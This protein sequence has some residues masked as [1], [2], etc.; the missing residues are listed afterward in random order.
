[1]LCVH[2]CVCVC[3]R[4]HVFYVSA[5][6]NAAFWDPLS[7]STC[8]KL[9]FVQCVLVFVAIAV[10]WHVSPSESYFLD[11]FLKCL[12]TFPHDINC[13]LTTAPM[14]TM[15]WYRPVLAMLDATTGSSKLPGTHAT[16]LKVHMRV[17]AHV[18]ACVCMCVCV[19]EWVCVCV[20]G[21]G[22]V[23][24]WVCV[25][26]GCTFLC[27]SLFCLQTGL[28]V[29]YHR[30]IQPVDKQSSPVYRSKSDSTVKIVP[31]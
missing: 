15:A 2:V 30:L 23:C 10:N 21:R 1:V 7:S 25:Y 11:Q 4:V 20:C 8:S 9:S 31:C 5:G 6:I 28:A 14:Q 27:P 24:V 26:A 17:C 22:C 13:A 16:C 29:S 19:S 3:V 12:H 18:C